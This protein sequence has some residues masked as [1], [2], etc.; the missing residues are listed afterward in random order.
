MC[1]GGARLTTHCNVAYDLWGGSFGANDTPSPSFTS[2]SVDDTGAQRV[3]DQ[4]D[5]EQVAVAAIE[6]LCAEVLA[7]HSEVHML[8]LCQ[9]KAVDTSTA[10][11]GEQDSGGAL[12][13]AGIEAA[14]T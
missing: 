4:G 14:L 7:L 9:H 3:D 6:G 13:M 12:D 2:A 10:T 11:R 1:T 8:F 5:R